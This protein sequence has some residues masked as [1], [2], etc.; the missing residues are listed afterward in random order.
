MRKQ[1]PV[2]KVVIAERGRWGDPRLTMGEDEVVHVKSTS[3]SYGR[4]VKLLV[5]KAISEAAK[6]AADEATLSPLR[7]VIEEMGA[8]GKYKVGMRYGKPLLW[9]AA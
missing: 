3:G 2:A 4:P 9:E 5:G 1:Y 8:A 7:E 6:L